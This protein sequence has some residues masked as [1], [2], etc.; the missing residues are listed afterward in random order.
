MRTQAWPVG[1]TAAL[2]SLTP[3]AIAMAAPPPPALS[4]HLGQ[5]QYFSPIPGSRLVSPWNNIVIRHGG[6]LDRGTVEGRKIG[7]AH[8]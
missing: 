1:V 2:I 6:L 7:R 3:I 4:P 8:V 5:Y